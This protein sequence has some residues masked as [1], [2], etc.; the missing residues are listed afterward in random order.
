MFGRTH[1]GFR[2]SATKLE[3]FLGRNR[4]PPYL[5]NRP[6]V[7][8]INL[9]DREKYQEVQLIMCSDGLLD[10][11]W[12]HTEALDLTQ[13]PEVW[14]SA[15]DNRNPNLDAYNNLALALLRDGL[16]GSDIDKVSRNLTVEIVFK[17]MDDTTILVQRI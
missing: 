14:F 6:D 16:G 13:L 4:T 5:S 3:D 1:P 17:W 15:L 11:Y 10:L 8:H 2:F 9:A 12:D 7:K